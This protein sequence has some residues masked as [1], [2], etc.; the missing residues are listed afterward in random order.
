MNNAIGLIG[1]VRPK[2][3]NLMSNIREDQIAP[4]L[5][6]L[7]AKVERSLLSCRYSCECY[8]QILSSRAFDVVNSDESLSVSESLDNEYFALKEIGAD[9][10]LWTEKFHSARLVFAFH[11][12]SL[13]VNR[14]RLADIVYEMAHAHE[15]P[16]EFFEK[17]EMVLVEQCLGIRNKSD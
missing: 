7:L 13:G 1:Q 8:D 9:K 6:A 11:L 5:I 2:L 12:M 15:S 4:Y 3:A 16:E 10:L 17:A 14:N